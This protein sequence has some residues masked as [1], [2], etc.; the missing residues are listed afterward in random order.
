M[1]DRIKPHSPEAE[2]S[3]LGCMLLKADSLVEIMSQYPRAEELFFDGRHREIF[4]VMRDMGGND[5]VTVI[6]TLRNRG[7]LAS[8]GGPEYLSSLQNN[9]A[10]GLADEAHNYANILVRNFMRRRLIEVGYLMQEAGYESE[11]AAD[12]LETAERAVMEIGAS[13]QTDADLDI[14][15]VVQQA[16]N[17]IEDSFNNKGA[18]RGLGVGFPDFDWM[19]HGLKAGQMVV[20]AAR[21]GVGKTSLAMNMAEN[22]AV[23]QKHPVGVFSL[24]MTAKELIHRM[25]CSRARVDSSNAQSGELTERNFADLHFST[26]A[27]ATSPL[28]ICEKGG[29]TISQLSA[30]ARRMYQR[31]RLKLLVI[32]YLQLMS[33]RNKGNRNEQITEISNGVKALAK[34]LRI[35]I[36][37]LSQLNRD[38]DKSDRE[39]KMADLRDSGSIEQDADII[40]LLSPQG[41]PEEEN[42]RIDLLV[43]KHRGGPV[44]KVKLLFN[45]RLTKFESVSRVED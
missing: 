8:I 2:R 7:V 14:K 33:S 26:K 41:K 39:P 21:P 35:P 16:I 38:V 15:A 32:D 5:M 13:L 27:I 37:V 6:D 23:D 12:A 44:G 20:I 36:V 24:E 11:D 22:V 25:A 45:K 31:Y 1:K 10:T 29:L 18:I 28:H 9:A 42:Q 30:R 4:E 3:L 43:P 17:E 19:T 34:D 40:G